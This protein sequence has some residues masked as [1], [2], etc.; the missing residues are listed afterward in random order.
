MTNI[1]ITENLQ[2]HFI[3]TISCKVCKV[4]GVTD[5]E[6]IFNDS[7]KRCPYTELPALSAKVI[8]H[9]KKFK[10]KKVAEIIWNYRPLGL[11]MVGETYKTVKDSL[12]Y[13]HE[14]RFEVVND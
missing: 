5:C 10:K 2:A 9:G 13:A 3:Q 1:I 12:G 7:G 14:V 11:L 6:V 4:D 8:V